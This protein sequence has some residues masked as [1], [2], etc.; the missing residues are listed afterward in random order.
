MTLKARILLASSH[1]LIREG[2]KTILRDHAKFVVVGESSSAPDTLRQGR[3]QQPDVVILDEQLLDP[4]EVHLVGMLQTV[5]PASRLLMLVE[6]TDGDSSRDREGGA[7]GYIRRSAGRDEIVEAV[8]NVMDGRADPALT[9]AGPMA[10]GFTRR[11]SV[12]TEKRVEELSDREEKVLRLM[13]LGL[14]NKEIA[15]RLTVSV[16]T[17][18]TYKSRFKKKL[19]LRS[20]AGVIRYALQRGWLV[21]DA[22][23]L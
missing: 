18:E 22:V 19:D 12:R 17:V 4:S 15:A 21:E 2:L 3:L 6:E 13:A 7:V 8:H 20:R 1:D 16:K 9:V 23:A 11:L 10:N 14:G 5:C